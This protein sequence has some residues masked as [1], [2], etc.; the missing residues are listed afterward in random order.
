MCA[1]PNTSLNLSYESLTS[2]DAKQAILSLGVSSPTVYAEIM[3]DTHLPSSNEQS[4]AEASM[5]AEPMDGEAEDDMDHTV[6]EVST[7]FLAA[8]S[9]VTAAMPLN[10]LPDSDDTDEFPEANQTP[11]ATSSTTRLGR[12]TRLS[13]RYHGRD[14]VYH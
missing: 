6:E 13:S 5:P 10:Q 8:D 1:V 14:W 4:S 7:F 12:V 3:A 11:A 2:R 9:A